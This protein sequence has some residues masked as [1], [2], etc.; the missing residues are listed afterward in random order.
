MRPWTRDY[1]RLQGRLDDESGNRNEHNRETEIGDRGDHQEHEHG[2]A[3][4][5]IRSGLGAFLS[6]GFTRFISI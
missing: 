4:T 6:I 2:R 5:P 1:W 3:R